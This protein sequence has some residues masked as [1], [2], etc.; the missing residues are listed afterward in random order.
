M[1]NI[2]QLAPDWQPELP[3]AKLR[4]YQRFLSVD[5]ANY[6]YKNFLETIPWQQ[7][8]VNENYDI[9]ITSVGGKLIRLYRN[10]ENI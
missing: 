1:S 3:G 9:R 5:R 7:D 4:Y 2:F 6:Y 10:R 8:D